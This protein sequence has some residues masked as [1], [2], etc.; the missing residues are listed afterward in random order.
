MAR[1]RHSNRRRRGSFGF[2]YKLLSTLVICG[3]IVAALTLFFR[4]DTIV[5]TG[6]EKYTAEE[7]IAAT[8]VE[9]GDNLFLLNKRDVDSSIKKALPYV[10]DTRINKKLPDVLLVEIVKECRTPLAV[11]QDGSAWLVSAR[12]MIVEQLP[13]AEA[14]ACGVIDGCKL[15]SPSVGTPIA[16]ATEYSSQ[17]SDLLALLT[18]LDEA[19]MLDQVDSIHLDD[20]S[21]LSMDYAG[22]FRVEM[23]YHADYALKVKALRQTLEHELVQDNMTGTIDLMQEE[24]YLRQN[25]G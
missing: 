8:G 5:V 22:R 19:G 3:V 16:L 14:S 10:E 11:V 12:G 13:A 1:R 25:M 6:E 9:R 15:L 20:L 23:P 24:V 4:V 17:Q 7:I 2:L 18:A 21:I